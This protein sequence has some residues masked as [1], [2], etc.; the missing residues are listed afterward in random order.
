MTL[1]LRR[2]RALCQSLPDGCDVVLDHRAD[3]VKHIALIHRTLCLRRSSALCH[4]LPDSCDAVLDHRADCVKHIALIQRTLC[5]RRSPNPEARFALLSNKHSVLLV[6]VLTCFIGRV[7][8]A[9]RTATT[10]AL[11]NST[12]SPQSRLLYI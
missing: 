7:S 8:Q 2:S 6:I 10:T 3:C 12:S 1:C 4:S 11:E 9:L 5:L